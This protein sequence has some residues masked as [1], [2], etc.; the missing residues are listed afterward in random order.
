MTNDEKYVLGRMLDFVEGRWQ[1]FLN[2]VEQGSGLT[3][4]QWDEIA[5]A[6]RKHTQ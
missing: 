3:E 1:A 5:E 2:E 6:L 4:D